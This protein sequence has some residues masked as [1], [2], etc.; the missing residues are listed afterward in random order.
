MTLDKVSVVT[1][2]YNAVSIIEETI[3]SVLDQTYSNLEY[4]VIDGGSTDGTVELIRKSAIH[5]CK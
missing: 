5:I 2:V 4:I 3:K 1:V